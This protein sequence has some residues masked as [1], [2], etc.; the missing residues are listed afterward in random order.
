MNQKIFIG[1]MAHKKALMPSNTI[2]VPIM[3][4]L[5]LELILEMSIFIIA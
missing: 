1:V 5:K 2:Y 4:Q 3:F